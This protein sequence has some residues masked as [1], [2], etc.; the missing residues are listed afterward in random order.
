MVDYGGVCTTTKSVILALPPSV[1]GGGGI[2]AAMLR[3]PR[4]LFEDAAAAV[5]M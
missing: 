4:P 2:A 5:E 1:G 3:L